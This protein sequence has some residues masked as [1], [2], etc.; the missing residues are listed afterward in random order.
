MALLDLTNGL[1]NV[2]WNRTCSYIADLLYFQK[3]FNAIGMESLPRAPSQTWRTCS[4]PCVPWSCSRMGSRSSIY[5]SVRRDREQLDVFSSWNTVPVTF[6]DIL[7]NWFLLPKYLDHLFLIVWFFLV[8][9]CPSVVDQNGL[10]LLCTQ[11]HRG[12]GYFVPVSSVSWG[13]YLPF[14][15]PQRWAY[16]EVNPVY[17]SGPLT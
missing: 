8:S 13:V 16:H 12:E 11:P 14:C 10:A 4:Q 2:F 5:M 3:L 17:A 6:L 1:M 7:W 9:L 15:C